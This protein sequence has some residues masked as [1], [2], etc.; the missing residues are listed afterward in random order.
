MVQA[1]FWMN[2]WSRPDGPSL[3]TGFGVTAFQSS[4]AEVEVALDGPLA[5]QPSHVTDHS[6][7]SMPIQETRVD[8]QNG[9]VLI[10]DVIMTSD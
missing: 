7:T 6:S 5:L 3:L 1:T 9:Q 8:P 4:I 10:S 2:R